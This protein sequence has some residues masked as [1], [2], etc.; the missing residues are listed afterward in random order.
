[1]DPYLKTLKD[2]SLKLYEILKDN[3]K[4]YNVF[5]PKSPYIQRINNK[6]RINIV[7]KC[8]FSI[9]FLKILYQKL[10]QYDKIKA[11]SVN[12]SITKN[13]MYIG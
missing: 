13:P 1:M 3:C 11:K 12:F 10:N 6:Y 2:D 4:E 9:D 5:S 8:K 7:I